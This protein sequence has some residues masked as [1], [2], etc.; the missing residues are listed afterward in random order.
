MTLGRYMS[1]RFTFKSYYVVWKLKG[2]EEKK[3]KK[4]KFKSY[5]VVW[6]PFSISSQFSAKSSV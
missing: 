5:Y 6:K 4:V 3:E 1:P 2:K